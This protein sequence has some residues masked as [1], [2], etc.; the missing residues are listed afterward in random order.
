M[1]RKTFF[2]LAAVAVVLGLLSIFGQQR[3]GSDSIAGASA[4]DLL[5]P[6]LAAQ[7]GAI[8]RITI[9]GA[10][11]EQLVGLTK[12][13]DGWTVDE[14]DSYPAAGAA[15]TS[16][17]IALTE[18]R[19][20]EEKTA[21]P[22]F[23]S[24]L[25]VEP[26]EEPD[27]AGIELALITD[28]GDSTAIILGDTYTGNQRYARSAD[29]AI[30]VLIDRNPDIERDPADWVNK[31]II[32]IAGSR[33]QRV[34]IMHADGEVLELFKEFWDDTDFSVANLP[35][36]RELQYTSIPNVT[37]SVLQGLELDQVA[38]ASADGGD[39]VATIE[40]RT[41]DGLAVTV[42]VTEEAGDPWLSFNAS[43]DTE[44]ALAFATTPDDADDTAT[45]PGSDSI[46]EAEAINA[47]LTGWRYRIPS[48][49]Y[50]QLTR[51][52]DDLL[53]AESDDE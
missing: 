44:Q 19:I 16:L 21:N 14:Q 43:F 26:I 47:R 37:G 12:R 28:A 9:T 29:S 7:A 49:K 23:Y 51:R 52:M 18:A 36:G 32:D 27:A 3:N 20:V 46:A 33:V 31:D 17:L 50:S 25:G 2:T 10:G 38:S 11:D 45:E 34:T 13:N 35:E 24:R 15:V 1:N 4:G 42:S 22:A 41:F 6:A 30:S 5:L 53:L 40:F 39:P 8:S 48:Y